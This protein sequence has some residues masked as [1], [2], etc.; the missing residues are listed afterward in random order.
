M[1]KLL[2]LGLLLLAGCQGV[3]G[4]RDRRLDPIRVD[5]P[6]L[7]TAQ[8]DKRARDQLPLPQPSPSIAPSTLHGLPE[9]FGRRR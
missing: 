6:L 2:C 9:P 1:R 4:P 7:T 5:N 3:Q 8:Q